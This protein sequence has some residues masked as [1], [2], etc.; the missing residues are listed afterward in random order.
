[1][2][3]INKW[4]TVCFSEVTGFKESRNNTTQNKPSKQCI[5]NFAEFETHES[6]ARS[7]NS[8]SLLQHL[9]QAVQCRCHYYH[10]IDIELYGLHL[11]PDVIRV[12]IIINYY[13]DVVILFFPLHALG[14]EDPKGLLLLLLLLLLYDIELNGS[15]LAPDVIRVFII[16][17]YYYDVVILFFPLHALG[18]EDPKGLL[19]LLLLYDIELNGSHFAPDAD[20][21]GIVIIPICSRQ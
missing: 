17:N 11:A 1:V 6:A 21:V 10:Y 19:L 4:R 16:I 7:K 5:W 8:M 15:H 20:R 2:S 3:F 14:S 13:Y 18:S 12:F 9:M